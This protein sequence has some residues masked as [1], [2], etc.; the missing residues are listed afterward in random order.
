MRQSRQ[1]LVKKTP[2]KGKT[3]GPVSTDASRPNLIYFQV[4]NLGYGELGCYG[5]GV[6]RG[7]PTTRIDHFAGEGFKL[8][9]FAPEAQC[10]P[11]RAALM[12][13][14]YAIR[15]GCH[16][17]P[18]AGQ[19]GGLVA[20]EKTM[21][22][23]LSE[24]GYACACYGKWHL[25]ESKGRWPTDHGFEE[26]YGPIRSYDECLWPTR[27]EYNPGRDLKSPIMEGRKNKEVTTAIDMMTPEVRRDIDLEYMKRAESFIKKSI[28]RQKPFFLY[29]NH[30]MLH[31]PTIPRLD[32]QGKS[33][34]GDFADSMLELDDDFGKI[35]NL[36]ERLQLK[37]QTI[38]VFAGDNGNEETLPWRGSSGVWEGSYFT[39]MEASLRT[40]CLI[41]WPGKVPAGRQSNAIVHVTDMFTTLLKW[42]GCEPPQ[43]RVID[44]LDQR[45]FLEGKS[46]ESAREGFPFWNGDKLYGIKWK[47]FKVVLFQQNAF[48]DPV[49]PYAVPRII[50]LKTDPK[51]RIN[52]TIYYGWVGAHSRK[53]A[54]DFFLSTTQEP[55]TPARAPID[56][57][58]YQAKK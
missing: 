22:D 26:W 10:T 9:N 38:V 29:F 3:P 8:L 14:R 52:E 13:G 50:N 25:G 5:G 56:F 16:T 19:E 36:I 18:F 43:D 30:S 1:P 55:L 15:S 32:F 37:D 41:R 27:S 11:T 23:I 54:R 39:G 57:N 21:A 34:H 46:S 51:E 33:G 44:G 48:W 28:A 40:P 7:A 20:W 53:I 42:S 4:D 2:R 49:L 6:L 24:A 31:L 45:S 12:T 58:P 17:I 47:D 35:L